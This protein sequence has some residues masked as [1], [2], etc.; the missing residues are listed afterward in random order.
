MIIV[1]SISLSTMLSNN[2]LIPYGFLWII[3]KRIRK[4]S[5]R[6]L[7][8]EKIGIFTN[9]SLIC[10]LSHICFG[11]FFVLYWLSSFC[12]YCTI[13][14]LFFGA[15]FWK[16]GSKNGAITELSLAFSLFLHSL[17]PFALWCNQLNLFIQEGPWNA[18]L[19]PFQLLD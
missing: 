6:I 13:S 15:I 17:I 16:R 5:K 10:H 9:N 3:R 14:L 7:T 19:K 2:L 12:S 8:T 1:S 18:L 4:N 11:L